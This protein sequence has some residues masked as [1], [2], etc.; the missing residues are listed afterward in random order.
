MNLLTVFF[1]SI[2]G[3][4]LSPSADV[5][6]DSKGLKSVSLLLGSIIKP[7]PLPAVVHGSDQSKRE[8]EFAKRLAKEDIA[9]DDTL[10]GK[11]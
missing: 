11:H 9:N 2:I 4:G 8:M 6:S 7:Y 3:S 10:L 1:E 5:S